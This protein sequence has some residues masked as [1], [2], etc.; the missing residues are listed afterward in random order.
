MGAALLTL[1]PPNSSTSHLLGPQTRG[2]GSQRQI[3]TDSQTVLE[4][5]SGR[6]VASPVTAAGMLRPAERR[7]TECMAQV[8]L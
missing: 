3:L 8:A 6:E 2:G 7:K 4:I 1:L 5:R